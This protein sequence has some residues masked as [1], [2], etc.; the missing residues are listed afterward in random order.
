MIEN[1]FG[2]GPQGWCTYDY[3]WSIVSGGKNIFILANWEREGGVD[4][5]GYIWTDHTR[6]SADTPEE[7]VSILPFLLYTNWVGLDR[8]DLRN[9]QMSVNLRG[10]GLFLDK[11]LCYF[12]IHV[13]GTRW[14]YAS[15]PLTISD[16]KWD[17]EPNV[18]TLK[19]DESLWHMSWSND[20][21]NPTPLS[22]VIASTESFGFSLVGF[23]QEPRGKF[24]MDEF[25]IELP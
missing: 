4:G 24:C 13:G 6:W 1:G 11:A 23:K 5:S 15:Q 14:H 25:R 18:I 21:A 10:D 12:W 20:P 19:D 16:G 2:E 3:H 17:N 9:A 7:P 8:L 22:D